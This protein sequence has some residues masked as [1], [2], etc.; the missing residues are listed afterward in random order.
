MWWGRVGAG[1]IHVRGGHIVGP[2]CVGHEA[3]EEV[4]HG[5]LERRLEP[6]MKGQGTR[7]V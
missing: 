6:R 4:G 1:H 2:P 7:H 5:A 3:H